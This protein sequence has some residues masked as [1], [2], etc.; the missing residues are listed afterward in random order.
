[1]SYSVKKV[2]FLVAII[3]SPALTSVGFARSLSTTISMSE[4]MQRCRAAGG[5]VVD[6]SARGVL[7]KLPGGGSVVC[8]ANDGMLNC[9]VLVEP[10]KRSAPMQLL[11]QLEG[12]TP[13]K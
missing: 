4:F 12:R 7:C 8:Y 3:V 6:Y 9:D 13:T 5:Q 2:A 1:M 10:P 11:D